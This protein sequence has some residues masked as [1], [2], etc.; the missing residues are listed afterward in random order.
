M[1]K[2]KEPLKA[3]KYTCEW[4]HGCEDLCAFVNKE[5]IT[6]PEDNRLEFLQ[7]QVGGYIE[8][9]YWQGKEYIVD[10]EGLLKQKP[11]NHYM[12][13][14]NINLVGTVLEIHGKLE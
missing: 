11:L 12:Q 14:K 5:E 4:L 1:R 9:V 10:E 2:K 8:I 13:E 6:I 3:T 7:K